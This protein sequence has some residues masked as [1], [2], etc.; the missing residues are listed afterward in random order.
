MTTKLEPYRLA[1]HFKN[2]HY[3]EI[4]GR[5]FHHRLIVRRKAIHALTQDALRGHP[6]KARRLSKV[7]IFPEPIDRLEVAFAQAQQCDIA[8][9]DVRVPQGIAA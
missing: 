8:G 7:A 6:I 1:Y 3:R 5:G 9:E 4:N 2:Q